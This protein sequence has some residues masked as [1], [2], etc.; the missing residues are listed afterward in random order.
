MTIQVIG[1]GCPT[2]KNL[3]ETTKKMA[4]ELNINTE[5]EYITDVSKI[6]EMGVMAGP[7]LVI[8]SKPVLT[9][10]GHSNEEIKNA[11]I[12]NLPQKKQNTGGCC[13]CGCSC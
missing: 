1:S 5:V 11:L 2:C 13:S 8:D 9:G 12:N 10:G 3:Y 6:I 4:H 7:V